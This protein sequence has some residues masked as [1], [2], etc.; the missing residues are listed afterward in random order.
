[1]RPALER[2]AG[3]RADLLER[4][5]EPVRGGDE[6]DEIHHRRPERRLGHL[7]PADLIGRNHAIGAGAQDLAARVLALGP[8]DDEQIRP[9]E[10]RRQHGVD[11]LGVGADGGDEGAGPV[12]AEAAQHVLGA[13]FGGH[14]QPAGLDDRCTFSGSRSTTTCGTSW[15]RNSSTMIRPIRP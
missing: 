11:V 1:M 15:R 9:E 6:L 13:G 2:R 14:R 4:E 3:A 10:P 5:I 12:D 7:Q 8:G